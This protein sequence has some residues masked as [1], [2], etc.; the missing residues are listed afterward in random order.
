MFNIW[1]EYIEMNRY[2]FLRKSFHFNFKNLINQLRG[3]I[4]KIVRIFFVNFRKKEI[5]IFLQRKELEA[6]NSFVEVLSLSYNPK[7]RQIN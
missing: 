6:Y 2:T 3:I 7:T 4:I 1:Q 5:S